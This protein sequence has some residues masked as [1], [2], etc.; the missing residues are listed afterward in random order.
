[1]DDHVNGG[2][3]GP[4]MNNSRGAS[5]QAWPPQAEAPRSG[6]LLLREDVGPRKLYTAITRRLLLFSSHAKI[7][8]CVRT[9]KT[10]KDKELTSRRISRNRSRYRDD[11]GHDLI[12]ITVPI[13]RD[14]STINH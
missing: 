8:T 6:P 2:S 7:F 10:P 1:M 13:R 11:D 3:N 14:I 4:E 12:V 9:P 5:E